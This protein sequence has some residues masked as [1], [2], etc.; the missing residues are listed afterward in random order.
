MKQIIQNKKNL[1][2]YKKDIIL[3]IKNLAKLT[4]NKRARVC[5]HKSTNSKINEMIIALKKGS[6]IRPHMHPNSKPESYHVIEG[7]MNVYV[8]SKSGKKIKVVK[9]GNY[10]SK[11]NF[12]YRMNKGYFHFPIAVSSWCVYHEVFSGPFVKKKDVKYAKWS[13]DEND[14]VSV[15]IFLKKIGYK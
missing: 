12:F 11:L 6:Y 10:N 7:K 14:K 1:V 9:M 13:P 8:F 3:K 4:K 2:F 15:G 5:I